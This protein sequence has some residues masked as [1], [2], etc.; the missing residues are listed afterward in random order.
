MIKLVFFL[1]NASGLVCAKNLHKWAEK[2]FA[3]STLVFHALHTLCIVLCILSL[4]LSLS[5]SL[6]IYL[7][8]SESLL[9]L[10]INCDVGE[11]LFVKSGIL[12]NYV[13]AQQSDW[14]ESRSES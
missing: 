7:L 10:T 3:S 12:S 4:S 1:S 14:R 5:H 9:I 2:A 11:A 13:V 8:I 6:S